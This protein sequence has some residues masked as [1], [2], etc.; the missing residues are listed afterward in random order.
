MKGVKN[1]KIISGKLEK[2]TKERTAESK[3]E[4]T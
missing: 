1:V 3:G 4:K 2:L